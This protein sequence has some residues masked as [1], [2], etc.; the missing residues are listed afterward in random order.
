MRVI[1][2]P[3]RFL[4][5]VVVSRLLVTSD[6]FEDP[7]Q[8]PL[9]QDGKS[10]VGES[11]WIAVLLLRLAPLLE[12]KTI[13]RILV[14]TFPS[15]V[16]QYIDDDDEQDLTLAQSG[17]RCSSRSAIIALAIVL[18]LAGALA[19]IVWLVRAHRESHKYLAI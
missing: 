18:A 8:Q 15:C 2:L 14:L 1:F 5:H 12:G 13:T 3:H 19:I 4:A 17:R 11:N 7:E 9:L 10:A 16:A 6:M